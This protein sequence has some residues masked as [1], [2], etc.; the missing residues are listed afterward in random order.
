MSESDFEGLGEG[1][2]V[3]AD[4]AAEDGGLTGE[5]GVASGVVGEK[6]LDRPSGAAPGAPSGDGAPT[7]ELHSGSAGYIPGDGAPNGELHL[8]SADHVSGDGAP[9]GEPHSESADHVPTGEAHAARA[10][11]VRVAKVRCL[12]QVKARGF[13]FARG[14][15]VEGVPLAHAEYLAA[16]GKAEILEVS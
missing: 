11:H 13:T 8:E 5:R 15:V 6:A 4:A 1:G 16:G 7:G 3:L 12:D 10:D 9:T 14:K 2:G